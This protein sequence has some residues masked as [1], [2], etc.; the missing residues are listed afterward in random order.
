MDCCGNGQRIAN[1]VGAGDMHLNPAERLA[2]ER[3]KKEQ[4]LRADRRRAVAGAAAETITQTAAS[5]LAQKPYADARSA[6]L[7]QQIEDFLF[8]TETVSVS[9]EKTLQQTLSIRQKNNSVTE[10]QLRFLLEIEKIYNE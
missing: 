1:V 2:A 10:D 3:E 5:L 9:P 4:L 6:L 8:R 7:R